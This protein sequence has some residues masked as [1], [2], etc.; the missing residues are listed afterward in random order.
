MIR[1]RV[2]GPVELLDSHGRELRAVL[3][4]PKRLALLACLVVG[5]RGFRRRDSLLA[6]LW[7]ELD[8]GRAR[9]ALNQ[10]VRFLRKELGGSSESIIISRGADELGIDPTALW[11]DAMEL[12]DH[13]ESG[14]YSETLELYR[15]NLLEGFYGEP[16][17]GFQDWLSRERELLKATAARAAREL[18]ATHE[19]DEH[20]TPAVAS[21]RR[22]VELAEADERMVRQ[23]L[24][25]LDRI[26]DRAGAVQAYEEFSARLE[27]E[28]EVQPSPETQAVIDRIRARVEPGALTEEVRPEGPARSHHRPEVVVAKNGS[29]G[30][31][32]A[33]FDGATSPHWRSI[34]LWVSLG[35]IIGVAVTLLVI[36]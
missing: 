20:Y 27:R 17:A 7:P 16:G 29:N 33:S 2:L 34:A 9:V 31:A 5:P 23:L 21:A 3:A 18:A 36:R 10:A 24:Q 12:R 30:H 4:Q 13:M 32:L 8:T 28:Y 1:L 22:A 19:R 35:A 14:R 6:L 26:G 11:C 25:L 15:G